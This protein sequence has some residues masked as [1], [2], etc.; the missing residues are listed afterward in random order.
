MFIDNGGLTDNFDPDVVLAL[1]PVATGGSIT[2]NGPVGTATFQAAAGTDFTS[3]AI[4]ALA[5]VT[6][7]AGGNLDVGNVTS[8]SGKDVA[9]TAGNDL[10]AGTI[11][12]AGNISLDAGGNLVADDMNAALAV[13]VERWRRQHGQRR[14]RSERQLPGRRHRALPGTVSAPTITVTSSDI[15]VAVGASLGVYG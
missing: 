8:G 12:S 3:G 4:T 10:T 1:A 6:A 15:D 5:G 11:G 7:S 9:L 14:D 13:L 2:I